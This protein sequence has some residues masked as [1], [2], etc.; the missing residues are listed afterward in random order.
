MSFRD[1]IFINEENLVTEVRKM[2]KLKTLARSVDFQDELFLFF[3]CLR[4]VKI[5]WLTR[6]INLFR[7]KKE[8]LCIQIL[9]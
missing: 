6:N 8:L 9:L 1:H 2:S 7:E 5:S 4:K 3:T